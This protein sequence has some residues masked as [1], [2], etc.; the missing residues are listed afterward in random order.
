MSK[1]AF[2]WPGIVL[3]IIGLVVL[4]YTG[5]GASA[6]GS[7][8]VLWLMSLAAVRWWMADALSGMPR[9][10]ANNLRS[11]RIDSTAVART[12]IDATIE[13]ISVPLLVTDHHL[14]LA[15]NAAA[16]ATL[17]AYI[18]GQAPRIALRH[19]DAI[20]LLDTAETGAGPSSVSISGLTGSGSL[21]QLSRSRIADGQWAIEL[22]DRTSEADIGRAQ[23]D[24]VANA[25]HELRTPLSSII[26]YVETIAEDPGRLDVPT[27]QR[28]LG[29]VLREARRM[30]NLVSDLMSLSQLEA[31]KHDVPTTRFELGKLASRVVGEFAPPP[32]GLVRVQL[33]L[34]D[35]P[36]EVAGDVKQIEQLLRNLI[37]NGLKYGDPEQVVAVTVKPGPRNMAEFAV[38]DRGP[39]I[40]PD[41]LPHLTRRFYRTDP[42]RSRA[43]GG[44]G[45]GLAIV[46]H[47]VERHRGKLDIASTVGVGTT[48]CVRLPQVK[49]EKSE[50][51]AALS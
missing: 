30:Q 2:P 33:T 35:Q 48:V 13:A 43:A 17:G 50:K 14:I 11:P 41:H 4:W 38:V 15:A 37:D 23:T 31:E 29:T 42:G 21:W 8:A 5:V 19:P 39:G 6:L 3:A 46:K 9:A 34:P 24:F 7:V 36:L 49:P 26:G 25:S 10:I 18:V 28:F 51:P 44:T 20:K 47:I 1:S 22:R 12:A 27:T 16:R 45:L 32:G 40:A